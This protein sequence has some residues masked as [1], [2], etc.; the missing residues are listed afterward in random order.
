[1]KIAPILKGRATYVVLGTALLGVTGFE[2]S[3]PR[4]ASPIPSASA[5]A[6]PAR[7]RL[8]AEGRVVTYP[9]GDVTVSAEV[10]GKITEL[11]FDE[12]DRVKEGDVLARID[13]AIQRATLNEALLRAKEA[14]ADI[15]FFRSERRRSNQ[16][17]K[18]EAVSEAAHD[19]AV[20]DLRAAEWRQASLNAAAQRIQTLIEKAT[21]RAPRAGVVTSRRVDAGE[22]VREGDPLVSIADLEHSRIE[23]EV[24][25][26]DAT[27]VRLGAKVSIRVESESAKVYAGRIE[28]IPDVVVPRQLRPM[29]PA[30]PVD[31]RVLLVKVA[32]D[33]PLP[34]KLGQRVE[35]EIER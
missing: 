32:P 33:G 16:L 17:L 9:G 15:D 21:V 11:S 10:G 31:T 4:E 26:F 14:Q 2:L 25:E 24:G 27:G 18:L 6:R 19:R 12:R 30:N 5:A 13:V 20:H 34:L 8:V 23:A 28:E 35:I 29:D 1:M 22:M 7:P 3:G